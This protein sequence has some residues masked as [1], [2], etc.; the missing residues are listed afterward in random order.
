MTD[1]EQLDQIADAWAFRFDLRRCDNYDAPGPLQSLFL[2]S[3]HAEVTDL[4]DRHSGVCSSTI[5]GHSG[6]RERVGARSLSQPQV[7]IPF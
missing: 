3:R 1:T 4:L 7:K 6:P 5:P 2:Q